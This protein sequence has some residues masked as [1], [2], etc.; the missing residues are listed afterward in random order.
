MS[1]C[2]IVAAD[3]IRQAKTSQEPEPEAPVTWRGRLARSLLLTA[4]LTLPAHAQLDTNA[5]G[6]SDV[7]ERQFNRDNPGELFDSANPAHH[8]EADPDGDGW[9]N[10][11]ESIAGTDP[12]DGNPPEGMI[13]TQI[14]YL[15]D[16]EEEPS[17]EYPDGRMIDLTI[18]SWDTLPG[19]EYTVVFSPDLSA[20]SWLAADVPYYGDGLPAAIS[21]ILTDSDGLNPDKLFWRVQ[22]AD[23][24]SD[25]DGL[26]DYEEYLLGSNPFSPNSVSEYFVDAWIAEHLGH[27]PKVFQ[28]FSLNIE[29]PNSDLTLLEILISGNHPASHHDGL[30]PPL[31]T[32]V[33]SGKTSAHDEPAPAETRSRPQVTVPAG[34]SAMIVV[35]IASEEFPEWTA[36]ES[37]SSAFNDLLQWEVTTSTGEFYADSYSVNEKNDVEGHER[38]FHQKWTDAQTM[39]QSLEG[40]CNVV[41]YAHVQV[42]HAPE[43]EDLHLGINVS[44]Q[45][46]HDNDLASD[47]AV[48]ILP[49]EI[50][51]PK[52]DSIGNEVSGEL[53]ITNELKVAKMEHA[54]TVEKHHGQ[55]LNE[56]LDIDKDIDRFYIR[57]IGGAK[58]SNGQEVSVMLKT[59]D[60]PKEIYN[61]DETEITLLVE[62]EDLISRSLILTAD[63]IDDGFAGDIEIGENNEKNDRTHIIQLG[64]NVVLSKIIIGDGE[65]EMNLIKPVRRKK[66]V[67]V[68]FVILNDGNINL[69]DVAEEIE[70]DF[71]VMNERYAQIGI[72]VVSGEIITI[73]TPADLELPN[74]QLRYNKPGENLTGRSLSD[75]CKAVIAASG[76]VGNI[77]AIHVVYS[78]YQLA[79]HRGELSNAVAL[80]EFYFNED[81]DDTDYLSNALITIGQPL[82][83]ALS[84]EIG[85][86][87]GEQHVEAWPDIEIG[88]AIWLKRRTNLMTAEPEDFSDTRIGGSR[89]L[90]KAQETRMRAS[91]HAKDPE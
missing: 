79:N 61:D 74:N 51:V 67:T 27:I 7:W 8:P 28:N 72:E 37:Q 50:V 26:T 81:P 13:A 66:I 86:V 2:K 25:G 44:A 65:H 12:F 17:P 1:V 76:A 68:N 58:L 91:V 9:T 78:P 18:I 48:G 84:H 38:N 47:I 22:V 82:R 52:V 21:I 36:P 80:A 33:S 3:C 60:N 69:D 31:W 32:A 6:M 15:K 89:R 62:N 77:N 5:N 35:A 70:G 23:L 87:L 46:V 24:D 85:H 40:M 53:T 43:S 59:T 39:G 73:P 19:K 42:L 10:H 11:Q 49:I 4:T 29:L 88:D 90:W 45:N 83:M 54:L 30:Q 64:G 16:Q 56:E 14:T 75:D 57:M 41:H 20:G 63:H 55:V 34:T 71:A